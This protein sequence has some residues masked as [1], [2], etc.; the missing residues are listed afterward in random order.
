VGG[1]FSV[2]RKLF[3]LIR[4]VLTDIADRF[5]NWVKDKAQKWDAPILGARR[6]GVGA[7][8]N[9]VTGGQA[10]DWWN[11]FNKALCTGWLWPFGLWHL[12]PVGSR[13]RAGTSG[14][15]HQSIKRIRVRSPSGSLMILIGSEVTRSFDVFPITEI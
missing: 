13:I 5:Q 3:P 7:T 15:N 9:T 4:K 2:Y 1:F 11:R 6:R 14:P 8:L 10:E 12:H